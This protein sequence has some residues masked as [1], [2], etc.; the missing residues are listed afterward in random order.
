M[1]QT[2]PCDNNILLNFSPFSHILRNASIQHALFKSGDTAQIYASVIHP[3]CSM[4]NGKFQLLGKRPEPYRGCSD[5]LQSTA[6]KHLMLCSS[7]GSN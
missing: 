1:G 5:I 2:F 4:L 6:I 7:V 3:K